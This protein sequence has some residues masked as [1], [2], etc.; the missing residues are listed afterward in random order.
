MQ[1]PPVIEQPSLA[2]AAL[3]DVSLF[4]VCNCRL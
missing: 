3:I 2:T 4:V 1:S